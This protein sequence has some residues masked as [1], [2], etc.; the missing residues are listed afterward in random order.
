[1]PHRV[2]NDIDFGV[3]IL[4]ATII[5]I[6]YDGRVFENPFILEMENLYF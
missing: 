4:D 1:M 2:S 5:C 6:N 3:E